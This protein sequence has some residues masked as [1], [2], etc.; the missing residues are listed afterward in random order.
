MTGAD[1]SDDKYYKHVVMQRFMEHHH[2]IMASPRY[3][4]SG[5][6]ARCMMYEAVMILNLFTGVIKYTTR[7]T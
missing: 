7:G 5:P 4:A 2:N 1:A 6:V 3:M